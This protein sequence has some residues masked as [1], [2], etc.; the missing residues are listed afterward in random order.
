MTA[1]GISCSR[2]HGNLVAGLEPGSE[3]A[4]SAEL[5]EPPRP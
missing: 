3:E 5:E 4:G 2:L 1:A